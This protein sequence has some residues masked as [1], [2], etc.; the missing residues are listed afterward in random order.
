MSAYPEDH[1]WLKAAASCRKN[2]ST[3]F[4]HNNV[5]EDDFVLD[6]LQALFSD[7]LSSGAKVVL[8][9]LLQEH[10]SSLLSSPDSIEQVVGSLTNIYHQL[11]LDTDAFLKGQMLVTITDV[12]LDCSVLEEQPRIFLQFVDLLL[13]VVSRVNGSKDR[14]L[15]GMA[16]ECLKEI[17]ILHPGLLSRK[18]DHFYAMCQLENSYSCQS[19][20]TLFSTVLKNSLDQLLENSSS[21]TTHALT[22][23]L[24]T[25]KEPLK[26]LNLPDNFHVKMFQLK[27]KV[28]AVPDQLPVHIDTRELKRALTYLVDHLPLMTPVSAMQTSLLVGECLSH[29]SSINPLILKGHVSNWASSADIALF[30]LVLL[31][32]ALFPTELLNADEESVLLSKLLTMANHPA[33]SP[34]QRLLAF[35]W[36]EHFPERESIYPLGKPHL[37]GCLLVEHYTSFF[38]TVFDGLDTTLVKLNLLSQCIIPSAL[39]DSSSATLMGCVDLLGKS[40][41]YGIV[42]RPATSWYRAL[43][44]MLERHYGS[45]LKEEIMNSVVSVNVRNPKY[46]PHT[47]NFVEC[48][49][50]VTKD[51][52]F[53]V[54][55][56][57]TLLQHV[58]TSD[59]HKKQAD[60]EDYLLI[61]QR[62]AQEGDISPKPI[63]NYLQMLL[64]RTQLME[65]GSWLLGN[66]LLSVCHQ[67]L[68]VHS[69]EGIYREMG[70]T[71]YTL[72]LSHQDLEIRERAC[73]YYTILTSLS[74]EKISQILSSVGT[75]DSQNLTRLVTG[76]ASVAPASPVETL[77]RSILKLT[78]ICKRASASTIH[79]REPGDISGYNE[80]LQN[81]MEDTAIY[82]DFYLHFDVAEEEISS[83]MTRLYALMLHFDTPASYC[84]IP[85][86][87]VASLS[88]D[89]SSQPVEGCQTITVALKPR[90]P[91]P[92]SLSVSAIFSIADG[93]TYVCQLDTLEVTFDDLFITLPIMPSALPAFCDTMWEFIKKDE[94]CRAKSECAESICTVALS[95]DRMRRIL[96][97]DLADYVITTRDN[98]G[99]AS[100]TV[101]V[102][103]PPR[104][105]LLLRVRLQDDISIVSIV[106]DNWR[107][108][109]LVNRYLHCLEE[110]QH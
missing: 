102:L 85:D 45:I 58:V 63:L 91:V 21:T 59:I 39:H 104:W 43:F 6:I 1:R 90:E 54:L 66:K 38:P 77:D 101:A 69:K 108:L 87:T 3:F 98:Q 20:M 81:R 80:H 55:L 70:D 22:D 41:E 9:G 12:L 67:L 11:P 29:C 14:C 23:L 7:D 25:R 62:A 61:L 96:E 28:A 84:P 15:R 60:L 75:E 83:S 109:P 44:S 10:S 26:P 100:F 94:E 53:T 30:H 51:S 107:I 42:G 86:V 64:H 110:R 2:P 52:T 106:T 32:K 97:T 17:E 33:L 46:T 37:P 73:L 99:D 88:V 36:L 71:L 48:M 16:C 72:F 47:I 68:Q 89:S 76:S 40:L 50:Q 79:L 18:V 78:R 5:S 27:K 56:L 95:R 57:E 19:Y 13:D 49:Q 82:I 35:Q 103:L 105:H 34:G 93:Q 8:L 24:S 74:S 4:A 31:L 65:D 92:A